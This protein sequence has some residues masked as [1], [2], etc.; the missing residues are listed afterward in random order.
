MYDPDISST[1]FDIQ[2]HICLRRV[3]WLVVFLVMMKPTESCAQI[4][5]RLNGYLEHQYS[6]TKTDKDWLQVDYDRF[7]VDVDARAGR[8]TRASAALVWQL[9]RGDTR[10]D[11]RSILPNSLAT[12]VDTVSFKISNQQFINHAY[13]TLRP[14]NIEVTAGKQYLTWGA[15]WAFNPTELFRPKNLLEPTY[16]REGVGALSA[17]IALGSLSDIL[18]GL[19]PEGGLDTSGKVVRLRHHIAGYDLSLLAAELHEPKGIIGGGSLLERRYTLGGDFSGEVLGLGLWAEAAWS[20]HA[21]TQWI[22][23]TM[24]TNYTLENGLFLMVEGFYNG[25]GKWSDPYPITAWLGR[26]FEG[27]RSLGKLM[28]FAHANK[29]VGQLWTIGL[30]SL[31][32]AGDGSFVLIPSV[33]YA[34]AQ[35]V[36]ILFNGLIY[37]GPDGTEFGMHRQGGFLRIRVYF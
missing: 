36:D 15:G 31:T 22:E 26:F 2:S 9:F 21:G 30:S 35:D 37:V 16:E 19:V 28:V 20:D 4:R 10:V 23:A 13:V 27:Q 29:L 33:S 5:A 32:N 3:F 17:R 7:R 34:F 11:L 8:S 1:R 14:G 12:Q 6:L 25:R 18:V 24:G